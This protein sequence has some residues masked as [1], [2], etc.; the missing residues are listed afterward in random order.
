MTD[1]IRRTRQT[2]DEIAAR[3]LENTRDRSCVS[4]W[5]ERFAESVGRGA[6]VLDLGAGPGC[7]AAELRRRGLRAIAL[8]LSLGMLRAGV[9]EF[10]GPRMQA[11]ARQLPIR[12]RSMGGVWANASLLHLP[13]GECVSAIHEVRRI[14][15]HGGVLHIS[16][17]SGNGSEW[18][19]E[20]YGEPRWF[21]YWSERTLDALLTRSGFEIVASWSSSTPSADWLMRHAV[22]AML[23][24]HQPPQ[25]AG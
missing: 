18:E 20:R 16:V 14:L 25:R 9:T 5:L 3:F 12:D 24:P 8:D 10:P 1:R 17:K 6:R 19:T 23:T 11:D 15:A 13:H 2:Y 4:F 22:P 21:R 7:D